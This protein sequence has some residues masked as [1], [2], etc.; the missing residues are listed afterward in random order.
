M[1]DG[2]ISV[3]IDGR[4]GKDATPTLRSP[5]RPEDYS[6]AESLRCSAD[7][8]H[9]WPLLARCCRLGRRRESSANWGTPAVMPT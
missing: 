8:G 5:R 7:A 2:P 4:N 9:E 1:G 6:S 3:G